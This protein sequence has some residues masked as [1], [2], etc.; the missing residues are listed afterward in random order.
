MRV[1]LPDKG[2]GV[3]FPVGHGVQNCAQ[4]MAI[5]SPPSHYMGLITQMVKSGCILYSG[6]KCR[7]VTSAYPFGDKRH[8]VV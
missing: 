6:I 1:R 3:R 7:N 5:G 8:D 2:F 4:Y